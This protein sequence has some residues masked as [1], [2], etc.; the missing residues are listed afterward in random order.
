VIEPQKLARYLAAEWIGID[1]EESAREHAEEWREETAVML[2][3][4]DRMRPLLRTAR[5]LSAKLRSVSDPDPDADAFAIA[6]GLY[7]FA[8]QWHRGQWSRLYS[9]LSRV[10]GEP[11]MFRPGAYAHRPTEDGP[12]AVF[13][14]L[15]GRAQRNY[16]RAEDTAE[17]ALEIL[18][19][20]LWNDPTTEEG[21]A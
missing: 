15:D 2:A 18:A 19:A 5:E 21:G 6:E 13:R 9:V 8:S 16:S 14:W 3:D 4:D 7:Y 10:T 17:D 20:M 12:R 11:I 1:S